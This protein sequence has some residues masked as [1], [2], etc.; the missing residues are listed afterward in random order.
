MNRKVNREE[1]KIGNKRAMRQK[2]RGLHREW[3]DND[4]R[5]YN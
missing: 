5:V 3:Y 1:E 2:H 4:M